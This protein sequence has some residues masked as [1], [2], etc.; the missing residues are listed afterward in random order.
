[1]L[2]PNWTGWLCVTADASIPVG[3]Q[4]C[5]SVDFFCNGVME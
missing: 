2:P 1:M 4:C 3:A 5:F